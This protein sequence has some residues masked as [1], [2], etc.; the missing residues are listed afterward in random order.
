MISE[1]NTNAPGSNNSGSSTG[2]STIL[3][4][5]ILGVALYIGYKYLIKKP[6]EENVTG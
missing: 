5:A 1:F 4:L 2:M 3:K 6:S